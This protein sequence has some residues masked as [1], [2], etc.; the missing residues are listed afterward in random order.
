MSEWMNWFKWHVV[1][2][3]FDGLLPVSVLWVGGCVWAGGC[4]D[5]W[6][7]EWCCVGS[8]E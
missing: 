5:V 7:C 4:L 3:L 1:L 6:V 2:I 8:G